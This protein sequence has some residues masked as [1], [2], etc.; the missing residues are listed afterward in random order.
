MAIAAIAIAPSAALGQVAGGAGPAG[1]TPTPTDPAGHRVP[2]APPHCSSGAGALGGISIQ[3]GSCGHGYVN[4]L[5]RNRWAVSRIDMGI[6][7][8]PIRRTPVVAIGDAKII[9]SSMH[10][11]WPGGAF[12]W[13]RLLNGD[14][15]GAIVYVAEHLRNLAPAGTRVRAGQIIATAVPGWPG[16]EWGWATPNGSPRAYPCYHEG[17][18][19]NSGRT[20]VRFLMSL[21]ARGFSSRPKPGPNAPVGKRC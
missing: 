17:M 12:L 19:T 15:A 18:P 2:T 20:M 6:D 11:G 8:M 21:G 10:S 4:P 16:T 9:G 7:L 13:Y 14:H 3:A 5:R 1:T